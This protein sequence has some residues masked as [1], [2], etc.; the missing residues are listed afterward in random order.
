MSKDTREITDETEALE[1]LGISRPEMI[2]GSEVS[3][4]GLPEQVQEQPKTDTSEE[5]V[6]EVVEEEVAQKVSSTQNPDGSLKQ[7][8]IDRRNW[9][10][11]RDKALSE[12]QRL[13]EQIRLLQQQN[14]QLANVVTPLVTKYNL[15]N[16]NI[17]PKTLEPEEDFI[18]DGYFDPAKF[19]EWKKKSDAY[20]ASNLKSEL[21]SEIKG[22]LKKERDNETIQEQLIAIAK[23]FPE[24][25]NPLTGQVDVAR[26]Q[27]TVESHTKGKTLVDIIREAKG[28][29]LTP[30]ALGT[31]D[32]IEAI[33]RN[34]DRP[35]SVVTNA[36]VEKEP[37]KIPESLKKVN[38]IFGGLEY[39]PDFGGLE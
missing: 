25:V 14:A 2:P 26:V 29:N 17:Q 13:E 37:Q 34:A 36:D 3:T 19:K 16:E 30:E 38:N 12:K 33:K 5:V 28:K 35:Q 23:E 27:Q 9:Q 10:S 32:T 31:K 6:E 21:I 15:G 7:E 18:Q 4:L 39:P 11:E 22:E 1:R 20:M 24:F 8:E